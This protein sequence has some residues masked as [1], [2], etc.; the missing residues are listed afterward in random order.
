VC[1][2]VAYIT[3]AALGGGFGLYVLVGRA[4]ASA[5]VAVI[6]A[7]ALVA[8]HMRKYRRS[9]GENDAA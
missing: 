6:I 1:R 9:R 7:F 5:Y 2:G 3:A 4:S 8:F